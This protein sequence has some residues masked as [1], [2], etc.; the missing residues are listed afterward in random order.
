MYDQ[1][2]MRWPA[3]IIGVQNSKKF[4]SDDLTQYET[5]EFEEPY[6]FVVI[7]GMDM[8]HIAFFTLNRI[9]Q[10]SPHC[11]NACKS[12]WSWTWGAIVVEEN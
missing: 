12:R 11:D 4:F 2:T 1:L 6:I 3:H 7:P 5:I 9:S 8:Q 10:H